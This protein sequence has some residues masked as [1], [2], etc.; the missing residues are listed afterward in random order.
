MAVEEAIDQVDVA[1]SATACA[2]HK[3]TTQVGFRTGGKRRN[4]LMPNMHPLDLMMLPDSVGNTVQG[5]STDPVDALD[6]GRNERLD[7]NFC[8]NGGHVTPLP[9]SSM[10]PSSFHDAR[11]GE[12]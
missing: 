10:S 8:R 3:V 4:F 5:I 9:V 2:H 6:S 7:D 1:R 12:H 11:C